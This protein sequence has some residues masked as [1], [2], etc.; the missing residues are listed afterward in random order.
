MRLMR[1]GGLFW[2][3]AREL[4]KR[5][6]ERFWLM[7]AAEAVGEKRQAQCLFQAE[8]NRYWRQQEEAD[9]FMAPRTREEW[10][11]LTSA[12]RAEGE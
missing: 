3:C 10:I 11:A 8:C 6:A 1:R 4:T 9:A 12:S 7:Q 5:E 2:F